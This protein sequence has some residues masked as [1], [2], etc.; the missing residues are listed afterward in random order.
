MPLPKM[1][2]RDFLLAVRDAARAELRSEVAGLQDRQR[3][4]L[5][6]FFRDTPAIHYEVWVQ[7]KT[8]R[9]EMGLHFE[10]PREFSYAWAAALAERASELV[11]RLGPGYELE[12]WT[13]SWTRLHQ[14][15]V[16]PDL[17]PEAAAGVGSR[18][19]ALIRATVPLVDELAPAMGPPPARSSGPS[20]PLRRHSPAVGRRDRADHV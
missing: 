17:T 12:E 18:L 3:F 8:Q 20:R 13:A 19:A 14:T 2:V 15:S 11:A 1:G 10:G 4:S 9:L 16:L 6:Q 7:R 5:L